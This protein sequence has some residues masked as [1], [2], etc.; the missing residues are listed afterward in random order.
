MFFTQYKRWYTIFAFMS[1]KTLELSETDVLL[2][3]NK[4]D[5][6]YFIKEVREVLRLI[7][8]RYQ[9]QHDE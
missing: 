1:Q 5:Q 9:E 3:L 2:I 4:L 8:M 6:H 7:S